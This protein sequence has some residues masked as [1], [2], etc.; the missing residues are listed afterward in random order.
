[1]SAFL[2]LHHQ[3][4]TVHA[5]ELVVSRDYGRQK[6]VRKTLLQDREMFFELLRFIPAAVNSK[7]KPIGY[8]ISHYLSTKLSEKYCAYRWKFMHKPR[9]FR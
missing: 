5:V 2:P 6:Y 4:T 3:M 9:E 7:P 1:M 8:S